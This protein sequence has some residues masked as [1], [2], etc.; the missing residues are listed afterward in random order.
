MFGHYEKFPEEKKKPGKFSK[1][2]KCSI[3][4]F[5]DTSCGEGGDTRHKR[6]VPSDAVSELNF[7]NSGQSKLFDAFK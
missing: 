3:F 6:V 4:H 2:E 1:V 5:H 7:D